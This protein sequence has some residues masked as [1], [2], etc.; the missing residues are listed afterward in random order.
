MKGRRFAAIALPR[1]RIELTVSLSR[2]HGANTLLPLDTAPSNGAGEGAPG[3][4]P[5][6]VVI[7][8]PGGAVQDERTVIGGTRLDEVSA[9]AERWGIQPGMTVAAAR[10]KRSDLQVRVLP[11]LAVTS[12]L[13]RIAEAALAF[14]ISSSFGVDRDVVWVD[15]G[16]IEHLYARG[17]KEIAVKLARM[18]G[19]LGHDARVVIADGAYVAMACA[20]H[21]GSPASSGRGRVRIV[22]R[23]ENAEAMRRLPLEALPLEARDVAWLQRLGLSRAGDLQR[24]PRK[25][26]SVRL[27]GDV[28]RIMALLAGDDTTAPSPHVPPE[29]PSERIDLEYGA[30]SSEALLFVAKAACDRLSA[31]LAGRALSAAKLRIVLHLD[32]GMVRVTDGDASA[33]ADLEATLPTPVR[34]PAALLA[35]V[36]ARLEAWQSQSER[37]LPA[38]V[39]GMTLSAPELARPPAVELDLFAREAKASGKIEPLVAELGAELAGHGRGGEP[40]R[41][42]TLAV[43]DSWV[44]EERSRLVPFGQP[45][46]PAAVE[47]PP[48]AAVEPVRCVPAQPAPPGT[49]RVRLL[50]RAE[51]IGW[52][53]GGALGPVDRYAAWSPSASSLAFVSSAR[54]QEQLTLNGWLE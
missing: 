48:V 7:A 32:K 15:I 29:I 4:A 20:F 8:R 25:T 16:G 46:P 50:A 53:R 30:E 6:A 40:L 9:E 24:L 35:V 10:A 36:R 17:E 31:R 49:V 44:P 41:V 19:A 1:L 18:A 52:W 13:E 54:E 43:I 51:A 28:H 14:G 42:G 47:V 38:P 45:H 27:G 11:V 12:T 39:L 3:D 21:P 23:G 22:P 34:A 37:G 33:E 26:L 5:L 2:L